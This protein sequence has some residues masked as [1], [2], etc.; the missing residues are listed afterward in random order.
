MG[1]YFV[2]EKCC[3]KTMNKTSHHQIKRQIYKNAGVQTLGI[4]SGYIFPNNGHAFCCER[5]LSI[6]KNKMLQKASNN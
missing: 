3:N 2:I 5:S 4:N 6:D 1:F